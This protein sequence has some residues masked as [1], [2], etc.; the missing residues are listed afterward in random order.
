[1]NSLLKKNTP[2]KW[3]LIYSLLIVFGYLLFSV[4]W[5]GV[6]GIFV[7]G[8][9][10]AD[11][12]VDNEIKGI[13]S[14]QSY[15]KDLWKNL[16]PEKRDELISIFKKHFKRVNWLPVHLTSAVIPFSILGFIAGFVLRDFLLSG[17]IPLSLLFITLP[18]LSCSDFVIYNKSITVVTGV[19]AQIVTVYL[20]SYLGYRL[21]E[22]KTR[23]RC[24]Q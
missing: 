16:S 2:M 7:A 9:L 11:P 22:K 23:I 3:I 4:T 19:S 17:I 8:R 1:M 21:K 24:Q 18:V 15:E 14:G 12:I 13:I 20:F 10:A 5:G 6:F